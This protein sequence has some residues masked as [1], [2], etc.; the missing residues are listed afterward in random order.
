MSL[1]NL[2]VQHQPLDLVSSPVTHH[3]IRRE[4][5]YFSKISLFNNSG[6]YREARQE[7]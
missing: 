4:N 2:N 3:P 1:N 7:T 5:Y 6:R